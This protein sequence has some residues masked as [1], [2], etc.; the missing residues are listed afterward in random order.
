MS[1]LPLPLQQAG[2]WQ[3]VLDKGQILSWRDQAGSREGQLI[4][5]QHSL[6]S[7]PPACCFLLGDLLAP[8]NEL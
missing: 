6:L 4:V 3:L 1:S 7:I 8:W 5:K 2:C